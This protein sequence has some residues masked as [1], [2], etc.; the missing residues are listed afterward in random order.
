MCLY[1]HFCIG[2]GRLV[3]VVVNMLAPRV[4]NDVFAP[5]RVK[6]DSNHTVPVI[7]KTGRRNDKS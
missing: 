4:V 1:S 6:P 3:D 2:S 7:S 5:C